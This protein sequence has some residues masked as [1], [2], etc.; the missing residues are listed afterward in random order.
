MADGDESLLDVFVNIKPDPGFLAAITASAEAA[1]N[2]YARVFAAANLPAPSVRPP[3]V[4][5]GATGGGGGGTGGGGS[6]AGNQAANY[7]RDQLRQA[8]LEFQRDKAFLEVDVRI[9][10]DKDLQNRLQNL[11]SEVAGQAN[12]FRA[13]ENEDEQ[14][15]ALI[16]IVE[17]RERDLALLRESTAEQIRAAGLGTSAFDRN[18]GFREQRNAVE[19]SLL[20]IQGV[21][22]TINA[23]DDSGIRRQF[24]VLNQLLR[25]AQL[26]LK[27]GIGAENLIDVTDARERI[28]RI[29]DDIDALRIKAEAKIIVDIQAKT[30][31]AAIKQQFDEAAA[32]AKDEIARARIQNKLESSLLRG[33]PSAELRREIAL[34]NAQL[35]EAIYNVNRL[36]QGFDG[37]KESVERLNLATDTFKEVNVNLSEVRNRASQTTNSMNTLTNNAYQ[38]G[39]A[40]EDAAVG[41]SL[42]GLSGAFRGASNN[43]NFLINDVLRLESVQERLGKGLASKVTVGAAV[44]T[45]ITTLVLPSLIEWLASLDDIELKLIDIQDRIKQTAKDSDFSSGLRASNDQLL[46]TLR[47]AG[48]VRDILEEIKRIQFESSQGSKKVSESFGDLTKSGDIKDT[49]TNLNLLSRATDDYFKETERRSLE[50]KRFVQSEG[51]LGQSVTVQVDIPASEVAT[52]IKE[53]EAAKEFRK[54]IREARNDLLRAN[55]EV[56]SGSDKQAEAIEKANTSYKKLK[57]TIKELEAANAFGGSKDVE[58]AKEQVEAF[59]VE[60]EKI[61]DLSAEINNKTGVQLPAA[62]QAVVKQSENLAFSLEVARANAKGIVDDEAVMLEKMQRS[63]NEFRQLLDQQLI[64]AQASGASPDAINAANRAATISQYKMQEV[65]ILNEI[66]KRQEEIEKVEDRR[67]GKAKFTNFDQFAKDLQVNVLSPEKENKDVIKENTEEIKKLKELLFILRQNRNENMQNLPTDP[68]ELLKTL[69]DRRKDFNQ[70]MQKI[71]LPVEARLLL[72]L[73]D[74]KSDFEDMTG[75]RFDTPK[76]DSGMLDRVIEDAMSR[77]IPTSKA[78]IAA[79]ILDVGYNAIKGE[80][81]GAIREAMKSA[82][83]AIIRSQDMTTN[84][85]EKKDMGATAR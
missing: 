4:S 47:E 81:A 62:L 2:E 32:Y 45:A 57:E 44:A 79:T 52:R 66:K 84:A 80:I 24:D 51:P 40:F 67:A 18:L 54:N 9:A 7:L 63:N 26:K 27:Q 1:I 83:D 39:Q 16:R 33:L 65:E 30:D 28:Q 82:S 34:V 42:N 21:G 43:I 70:E 8:I 36:S 49:L 12:A 58:K 75:F 78:D 25:E 56:S 68:F 22:K 17:L 31:Q 14:L 13:T 10:N 71:I 69:E 48:S 37:S 53:F 77:R 6:G 64:I 59:R 60:L 3:N 85:V 35:E 74:L 19:S 55:I 20:G 73:D 46:E 29:T 72:R 11:T 23:A 61:S 38:L 76:P 5:G 15:N 50:R 41:Y